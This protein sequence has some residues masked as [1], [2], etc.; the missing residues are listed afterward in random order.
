MA[1]NLRQAFAAQARMA[2][3]R[4]LGLLKSDARATED[5]VLR[6]CLAPN[7][8]TV[9]G[10]EHGFGSVADLRAYR[11]AVPIRHYDELEPWIDRAA[12]GEP[13]VL[14]K[15]DPIRFWKTTGTT[16]KSKKIPLTPAA[17]ARVSEAF[18][19][20]SGTQIFYYP[21]VNE[22]ADTMLYSHIS[23]KSIKEHLG[24][25]RIPYCSTTEAPVDARPGYEDFVAP[26]L[27]PL[28]AVVE[29]D[30]ERLYFLLCFAALH[31]L[32]AIACLHPSRFQTV[33]AVL[34]ASWPR[35]VREVH[36]G[37]ILGAKTRDPRPD[38]ARELEAIASRTGTLLPKDVW[39]GLKFSSSWCGSYMGR[40]LPVM[41]HA[42]ASE[43]LAMP[44]ISSECFMTMTIDQDRVGQP[45]NLR[46]G[47]IEFIP[48]GEP[49]SGTTETLEFHQLTEGQTY[50]VVLT[51]LGGLYR[52][53]IGDIFRVTGFVGEVPRLEYVGRRAVSDLTGEKLAD[54]QVVE[55]IKGL[56]GEEA[57]N[58]TLCGVQDDG[59][60]RKPRYVFV[61]EGAERPGLAEKMDE[62][63]RAANSRYELKR[64]FKDL[65]PVDVVVVKKGTFAA[66]RRLL[67][68]RG[69]PAGQ[70]KDKVLHAAGEQVLKDLSTLHRSS[71]G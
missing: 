51:T 26:W 19:A 33:A 5:A 17:A 23:P 1:R 42:F 43:F 59:T 6:Q 67:I 47:V 60:G 35:L 64:S 45:L 22:R 56:L 12:A 37:T 41:Q 54:E 38:R 49:V 55:V 53:A 15:E 30:A 70:L 69:M 13:G 24:A 50:E 32:R 39:P 7:A 68:S 66:Y 11:A 20:L 8:E 61:L 58:C 29:D 3:D 16:S 18:L 31:D 21:E 27:L 36:E 44:S 14:T 28:Q 4:F 9:F 63:F 48:S 62:A 65:D 71:E 52:Y 40:Y 46:G 25:G 34:H 2:R 10:R 57:V